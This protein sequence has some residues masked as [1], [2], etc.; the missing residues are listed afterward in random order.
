MG[1]QP[2][3]QSQAWL[4]WGV[5]ANQLAHVLASVDVASQHHAPIDELTQVRRQ[6]ALDPGQAHGAIIEFGRNGCQAAFALPILAVESR[7]S[8]FNSNCSHPTAM[9]GSAP[10]SGWPGFAS[11][12]MAQG[13]P[14][15]QFLG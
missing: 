5:T 6:S 13:D 1:R 10:P 7:R 12:I 3:T 11:H 14:G 2:V 4:R 15:A 9:V 8:K